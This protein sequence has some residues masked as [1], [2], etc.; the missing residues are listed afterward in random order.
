[1]FEVVARLLHFHP[2]LTFLV[3]AAAFAGFSLETIEIFHLLSANLEFI[4]RHGAL[5]LMEG[6]GRQ[7]VGLLASLAVG[8]VCYLVFKACER[9]LVDRMTRR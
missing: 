1:M 8:L 3:M 4:A 2:V 5:A 7:F 9:I 6:A